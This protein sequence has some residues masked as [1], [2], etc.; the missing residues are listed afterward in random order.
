MGSSGPG[1][2]WPAK[3]ERARD[4]KHVPCCG[5]E[6]PLRTCILVCLGPLIAFPDMGSS[7]NIDCV[8]AIFQNI[9]N[10]HIPAALRAH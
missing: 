7:G 1:K 4:A 6:V 9:F 8:A 10:F 2:R 3:H 5:T